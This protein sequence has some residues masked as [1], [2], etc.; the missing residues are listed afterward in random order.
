MCKFVSILITFCLLVVNFVCSNTVNNQFDTKMLEFPKYS[1]V[2]S[3]NFENRFR[4]LSNK[5]EY[6]T[7][8]S[9]LDKYEKQNCVLKCISKKCY[10][11]IYEFN[12]LEEGE[13]DQRFTS[14]KGCYSTSDD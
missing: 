12:P 8:C 3:Y 5:C 2:K 4:S 1:I 10:E 6:K 14:F 13:I 7:D 11:E 9:H